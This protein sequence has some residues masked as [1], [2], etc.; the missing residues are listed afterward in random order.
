MRAEIV[1]KK[2]IDSAKGKAA[3][4]KEL[5]EKYRE[6]F[7]NPFVAEGRRLVDDVIEPSAT[8]QVLAQALEFLHTKRELRP[9]E[10]WID[11]AMRRRGLA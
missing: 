5:I 8:R 1:F 7:A 2:E 10:A 9:K 3:Q 6:A 11:S 4:R